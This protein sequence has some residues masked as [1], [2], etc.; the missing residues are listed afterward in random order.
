M[1]RDICEEDFLNKGY[2]K[3]NLCSCKGHPCT[4]ESPCLIQC[5]VVTFLNYDNFL[6]WKHSYIFILH[7]DPQ[8]MWRVLTTFP[9]KGEIGSPVKHLESY[10]ST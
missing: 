4:E 6:T 8:I 2:L 7:W 3:G 1:L 5:S 10:K 9:T